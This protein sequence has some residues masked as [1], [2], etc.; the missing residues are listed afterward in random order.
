MRY[1]IKQISIGIFLGIAIALLAVWVSLGY[2]LK[3]GIEQS[4]SAGLGVPMRIEQLNLNL[5]AGK[6][7]IKALTISNPEGFTTP[8]ILKVNSS[9]VQMHLASLFSSTLEIQR[10]ELDGLEVIIEQKFANSNILAIAQ[11][12]QQRQSESRGQ[13]DR[14]EK[15]VKAEYVLVKNIKAHVKLSGFGGAIDAATVQVPRIELKDVGTDN[16]QGVLFSEFLR[17]VVGE[18][19]T[20]VVDRAKS[21]LPK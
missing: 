1:R 11:K 18:I 9:D 10:V 21:A 17:K 13:G 3:S 14:A 6:V 16:A 20:A 4:A 12:L 5:A 8:Y 7:G 2:I 15:K 19:F